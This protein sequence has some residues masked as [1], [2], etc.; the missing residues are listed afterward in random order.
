MG[1]V[2]AFFKC[3]SQ[4]ELARRIEVRADADSQRTSE[5]IARAD[6]Q[7]PEAGRPLRVDDPGSIGVANAASVRAEED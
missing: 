3:G 4:G 1:L 6:R 2:A 7:S 5:S